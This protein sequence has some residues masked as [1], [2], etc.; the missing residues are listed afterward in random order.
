MATK[1]LL[2]A[3]RC[4]KAM[5]RRLR[6]AQSST[7]L[8]ESEFIRVAVQEFFSRYPK[9]ADQIVAVSKN[10]LANIVAWQGGAS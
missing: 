1:Q 7:G 8:D 10:R 2:I 3:A 4:S 6:V 5:K 9:P